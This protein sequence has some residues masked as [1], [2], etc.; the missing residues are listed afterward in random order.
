MNF[1]QKLEK[2]AELIVKRGISLQPKDGLII[3]FNLEGLDMVKLVAK[4]AYK[5]GV[6]HIEYQLNDDD[7]TLLR[8][9][10]GKDFVF[11]G[12]P[13]WKVNATENMYKQ[14]YS[15]IRITAPNP[16]LLKNIDPE[17]VAKDLKAAAA[18]TADIQKYPMS[19]LTKWCIADVPSKAWAKLVFPDLSVAD[20]IAKLWENIFLTARIT[21]DPIKAWDEHTAKLTKYIDYLNEK[22][23]DTLRY[24][25]PGTD[26]TVGM[27]QNHIWEGGAA[28]HEASQTSYLPNIPTEEVFSMPHHAKVNGT[29]KATKPLSLRGQIIDGFGFTFKDGKV[30]DFYAETGYETLE[31]LL[32]TDDGARSLGEIA[33]VPD[34]SPI[35]NTNLLFYNTL[36]DE[37]ASCHFALGRAYPGCVENGP[38]LSKEELLAAGGNHSLIHVDFMVGSKDLQITGYKDSK[39]H[40][41]FENGNW[42]F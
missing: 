31:K 20:G 10:H 3:I 13:Q 18:S 34:D 4:Q 5:Q 22:Q 15:I 8:Y 30:V 33:L 42:A 40:S 36:F 9:Q 32:N 26:L 23:F 6:K 39:A 12:V 38:Q 28:Y 16:Q 21:D 1:N 2:Y 19:G 7:L 24:I 29:L 41:I 25:A 17:L 27:P 35:S 37:N 14:N 11:E